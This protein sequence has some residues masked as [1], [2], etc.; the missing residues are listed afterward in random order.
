LSH[1]ERKYERSRHKVPWYD[2]A[3]RLSLS[4]AEDAAN[5]KYKSLDEARRRNGICGCPAVGRRV[6]QYGR[7]DILPKRVRA[8]TMNEIDELSVA[9]NRIRKREA[10]LADAHMDY[11][12]EK[13]VSIACGKLGTS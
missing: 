3:R 1:E 5:G 6:K 2:T 13:R 7:K 11:C 8:G 4:L 10:V 9:R 12:L